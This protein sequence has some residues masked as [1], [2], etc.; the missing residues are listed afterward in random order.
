MTNGSRLFMDETIDYRSREA[1]RFRDILSEI[2]SDLGTDGLSEG[3]RQLTPRRAHVLAGGDSVRVL[4]CQLD[5][6]MEQPG[7]RR[8]D[9]D[10]VTMM[11]ADRMR[12]VRDCLIIMRAYV[13]AAYPKVT[14]EGETVVRSALVWLGCDDPCETMEVVRQSSP[15]LT[16]HAEMIEA[17]KGTVPQGTTVADAIV[18]AVNRSKDGYEEF[19]DDD[20][21]LKRKLIR[22]ADMRLLAAMQA[23]A[24]SDG[25]GNISSKSLGR[26]FARKNNSPCNG[27]K[28]FVVKYKNSKNPARIFL[29]GEK[30]DP[31]ANEEEE[32]G[33]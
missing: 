16:D 21:L 2:L 33:F 15:D 18:E 17:W 20:G 28:F 23:V 26:W 5:A 29:I 30:A 9:F 7:T 13:V 4:L 14:M 25:H 27:S 31:P 10:P 19:K 8:F 12:Y 24:S 3:Q 1:R 11:L 6:K 32:E 22:A